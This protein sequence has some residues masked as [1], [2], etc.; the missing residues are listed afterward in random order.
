METLR[1]KTVIGADGKV[2]IEVPSGLPP[3]PA[4]VV[5]VVV[6]TSNAPSDVHWRDFYG[7]GEEIWG[8]ED[9]QEYVSR[10]RGEWD[11]REL[12][13]GRGGGPADQPPAR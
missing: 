10:L 1:T 6:P 3:G 8:G 2:K 9:A 11:G 12:D 7:L 5:V 4:D 13:P